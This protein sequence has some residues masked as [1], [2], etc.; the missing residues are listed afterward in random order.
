ME[1]KVWMG[2]GKSGVMGKGCRRGNEAANRAGEGKA[3]MRTWVRV[4]FV[5]IGKRKYHFVRVEDVCGRTVGGESEATGRA[6]M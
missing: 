3:R 4:V 1:E 6:G 5:C 2:L